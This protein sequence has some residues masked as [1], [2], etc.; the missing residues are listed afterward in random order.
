M[1][2]RLL[3]VPCAHLLASIQGSHRSRHSRLNPSHV[4]GSATS[5]RPANPR[6]FSASRVLFTR[7]S[8]PATQDSYPPAAI[9]IYTGSV[10]TTV[11]TISE[12]KVFG[13][14]PGDGL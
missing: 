13:T 14:D 9:C 5:R 12:R 7:S 2:L 1:Y 3:P 8:Q 6:A 10:V 11:L 4:L